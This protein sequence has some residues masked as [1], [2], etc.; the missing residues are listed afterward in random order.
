M[1]FFVPATCLLITSWFVCGCDTTPQSAPRSP[2]TKLKRWSEIIHVSLEGAAATRKHVGFLCHEYTLEDRDGEHYVY[3][4]SRGKPIGVVLPSGKA[5]VFV[6]DQ[7]GRQTTREVG[8]G[9]DVGVKRI[10]GVDG[11]LEYADVTAKGEG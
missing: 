2:E 5:L 7:N 9:L 8:Y 10:L 11:Q 6:E 4:R 1:R 3:D